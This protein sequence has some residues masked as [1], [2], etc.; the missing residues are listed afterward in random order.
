MLLID[1][2]DEKQVA[3]ADHLS[4]RL[5]D[6]G[7]SLTETQ[8]RL[9]ALN[10]IQNTYLFMFLA[11]GGLG[12]LVGSI[13]L[14]LV[15]LRNLLDRRAELGMLLAVGLSPKQLRDVVSYEH[16]GLLLAGLL[17]GCLA[18]LLAILPAMQRPSMQV[19][20]KLLGLLLAF[21]ALSG[22]LW[23]WL[24]TRLALSGKLMDALRSE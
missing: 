13:G 19:P 11:L 8:T 9:A 2:P 5:Q 24:A 20:Y 12:L 22:A 14:G 15:V 21:I 6:L 1:S 23:I 17:W 18:A 10:K 3:V 7:F 4:D 16:W